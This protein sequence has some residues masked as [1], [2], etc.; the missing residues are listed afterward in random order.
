MKTLLQQKL[1]TVAPYISIQTIWSPDP[2]MRD[3][4]QDCE[5]MDDENPEDWQAWQS[6]IRATA[7]LNGEEVSSSDYLGGTWERAGDVP[8]ES[9]PE[10]SGYEAQMTSEALGGL[11][12][13][14]ASD[15]ILTAQITAALEL[16]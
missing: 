12:P 5:G 7:I 15:S 6:E 8:E 16:L 9:N 1:A 11:L 4:R 14:V 2:D 3:I 13:L 10:I